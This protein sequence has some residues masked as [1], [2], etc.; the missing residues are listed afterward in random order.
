MKPA[1]HIIRT[2]VIEIQ[3]GSQEI[4]QDVQRISG[5][6]FEDHIRPQLAEALERMIGE[7]QTLRIESLVIE[8]PPVKHSAFRE[9]WPGLVLKLIQ[10]KITGLQPMTMEGKSDEIIQEA[11]SASL[12]DA[13]ITFLKTGSL[14]WWGENLRKIGPEKAIQK[15]LQEDL[16]ELKAVLEKIRGIRNAVFRLLQHTTEEQHKKLLSLIQPDF[17]QI[18][19]PL[20]TVLRSLES[21]YLRHFQQAPFRLPIDTIL[22]WEILEQKD[23]NDLKTRWES[24]FWKWERIQSR[25]GRAAIRNLFAHPEL[26]GFLGEISDLKGTDLRQAFDALHSDWKLEEIQ[27]PESI[28]AE[29]REDPFSQGDASIEK[30]GAK[31]DIQTIGE[32]HSKESTEAS[33]EEKSNKV[34]RA[35]LEEEEK[36]EER[37]RK[38]PI[39]HP[40][41]NLLSNVRVSSEDGQEDP[42]F[43]NAT[44]ETQVQNSDSETG[45]DAGR[46]PET[47]QKEPAPSELPI[48]NLPSSKTQMP[49]ERGKEEQ[50]TTREEIDANKGIKPI[51]TGQ[52]VSQNSGEIQTEKMDL[53]P[54]WIFDNGKKARKEWFIDNAGI[55]LIWPYLESF[56]S[57]QEL[58]EARS[59]ANPEKQQLAMHFVDLLTYGSWGKPEYDMLLNKILCDFPLEDPIVRIDPPEPAELEAATGLLQAVLKNWEPMK[60]TSISGLQRSFFQRSG[61]LTDLG[62]GWRMKVERETWD[63]LLDKLPWSFRMVKL[64]W[65]NKM[66]H[67]EW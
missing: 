22:L 23:V 36:I 29:K 56:F 46:T 44:E 51:L 48:H 12:T 50:R 47:I 52:H 35:P 55:V 26:P 1:P 2:Q 17:E 7:N 27:S 4:A 33:I 28:V 24:V 58:L 32:D 53:P 8:T 10:E 38:S 9:E 18:R 61:K 54:A 40:K 63:I 20:G 11:G 43:T 16:E 45:L 25:E 49:S 34:A 6:L 3:A 64:P 19:G 67:V 59:F 65:M 14:P 30:H 57:R 13:I 42:P 60:T 37:L 39:Q 5:S 15:L 41:S 31:R 21:F 62:E 66:I